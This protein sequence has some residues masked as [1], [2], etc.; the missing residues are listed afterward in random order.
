[1]TT[2][3]EQNNKEEYYVVFENSLEYEGLVQLTHLLPS[4]E[5]ARRHLKYSKHKKRYIYK[6]IEESETI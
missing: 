1:M 4:L 2:N 5:D 3:L 6:F